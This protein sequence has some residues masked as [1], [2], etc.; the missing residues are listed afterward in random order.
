MPDS[1]SSAGTTKVFEDVVRQLAESQHAVAG[2]MFG[3]PSV[4]IGGKACAGLYQEAM[5][6]KLGGEAHATA[7]ALRGAHL[8]DPSGMGRAMKEW[9]VVPV[10]HSARWPELG[11]HAV[12]YVNPKR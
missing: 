8:F 10:E 5:V 2:K 4:N 12:D 11:R 3:M 7:L 9:V 1:S 6:F